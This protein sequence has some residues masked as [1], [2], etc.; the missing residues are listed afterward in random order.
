MR[1]MNETKKTFGQVAAE[2]QS[3]NDINVRTIEDDIRSS[4]EKWEADLVKLRDAEI[5]RTLKDPK[6][7]NKDFYISMH[8][9]KHKMVNEPGVLIVSRHS[10]PTP[11]YNQA[12]FKY[13]RNAGTLEFLFSIPDAPRYYWLIKN[14]HALPKEQWQDAQF[15]HLME[16]GELEKWV[17]KENGNKPDGI[18]KDAKNKPYVVTEKTEEPKCLIIQP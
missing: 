15:C 7:H 6:F 1:A 14:M 13:H 8:F 17:I 18:I 10:C 5:A 9:R 4:R 16:T 12:V 2:N 11:V 3:S